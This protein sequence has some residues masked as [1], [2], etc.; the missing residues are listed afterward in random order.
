MHVLV[1]SHDMINSALVTGVPV[2]I[3]MHC[4]VKTCKNE[5]T[6]DPTHQEVLGGTTKEAQEPISF[7]QVASTLKVTCVPISHDT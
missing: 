2:C 1:Q 4:N 3:K 5:S 7:E 6:R